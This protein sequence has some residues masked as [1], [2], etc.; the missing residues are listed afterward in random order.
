ML[1][2]PVI[3]TVEIPRT[4]CKW[5]KYALIGTIF[6]GPIACSDSSTLQGGNA[7]TPDTT[8]NPDT[9]SAVETSGITIGDITVASLP[10]SLPRSVSFKNT[11]IKE[12]SGL[13]RS[14]LLPGVFYT[15]NDSGHDPVV[16]ITDADGQDLG[17]ISLPPTSSSADWEAIAGTSI[18]NI[19]YLIVADVGNNNRQRTDLS[20]LIFPEPQ[21]SALQQ[22]QQLT[23][24]NTQSINVTFADG[25]GHDTESAL[26]LGDQLIVIT[27]ESQDTGTQAIW[28]A[29]LSTATTDGMVAM[30]YRNTVALADQPRVNAITDIDIHPDGR[31]IAILVY[32]P[33]TAG[34]VYFW[35]TADDDSETLLQAVSREADA[36]I[37]VPLINFNF[38]AEGLSYS[39]D[40]KHILVAAE[41]GDRSTLTV[42]SR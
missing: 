13:Q 30:E 34:S 12:A 6:A 27:K 3:Q 15:H 39:S 9:D 35:R 4:T 42:L 10:L 37:S 26:V 23:V 33:N 20:L 16:Y 5:Y 2:R 7:T 14:A 8:T 40:G 38:Q 11:N 19:P 41:S 24:T 31:E 29:P 32:G 36:Q 1:N 28:S 22:N 21:L 25:L 17:Q 18:D